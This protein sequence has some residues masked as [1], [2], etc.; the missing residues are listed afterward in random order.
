MGEFNALGVLRLRPCAVL[1]GFAQNDCLYF[2]ARDDSVTHVRGSGLARTMSVWERRKV[3]RAV[4]IS[5][6]LSARMEAAKSAAFFAPELPM[7]KV[8]TGMP[9]GIWTMERRESTP[10]RACDCTGT[11]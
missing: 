1:R 8:A 9:P 6:L 5:E 10:W 3:S 4:A 7:A 2:F 11:P